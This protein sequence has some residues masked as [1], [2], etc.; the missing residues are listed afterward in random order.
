VA[1]LSGD[2]KSPTIN[3]GDGSQPTAGSVVFN[4]TSWIVLGSHLYSEEGGYTVTVTVNDPNHDSGQGPAAVGDAAINVT[5]NNCS[6]LTYQPFNGPVGTLVDSAASSDPTATF[7]VVIQWGDGMHSNGSVN[8]NTNPW[9]LIGGH[10]YTAVGTYNLTVTVTDD[11]GS[12]STCYPTMTVTSGDPPPP[13]TPPLPTASVPADG[14]AGICS[15]CGGVP[16]MIQTAAGVSGGGTNADPMVGNVRAFD[17]TLQ[18]AVNDVASSGFGTDWGQTVSWSNSPG[19]SATALNGNGTVDAQL[20]YLRQNGADNQ[21]IVI[22]DAS[23]ARYFNLNGSTYSSEFYLQE[24]LTHDTADKQFVLTDTTGDVIRFADFDSSY[25]AGQQGQFQSFTDPYGNVTA[26]TSRTT[27]G[28]PA[29]VQRSNTTGGTTTT[30]SF[31]YTY[32]SSGG[33]AGLISNVTLRRQVN[34]GAWSTVRQVVYTYYDGIAA[35]GNIGDLQLANVEDGSGNVLATEYY[36]YYT[37]ESG[38]YVHGLKYYFDT[39]AY[40]RLVTAVGSPTT[41]TDAQVANYADNYFQYNSAQQVTLERVQG[42]GSSFNQG[43]LG[44]YYFQ[45]LAAT[46]N[47]LGFNSWTY[48]TLETLPDGSSHTIYTNYAGEVMLDVFHDPVSG[49]NWETFTKYDSSGRAIWTAHTSAL[50]GYTESTADLLN[51]VNGNYQ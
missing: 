40:G 21:I 19:Y 44:V 2:L 35:Y 28:T 27:A 10:T 41:A 31:L 23:I 25:P 6:A 39:A 26:V 47:A 30:E 34:G 5:A 18:F 48:K 36:R 45:Y 42:E 8:K 14:G 1:I 24:T 17:G 33:N 7:S 32:V 22:S 11:G 51:S 9:T 46:G 38:G 15:T 49:N 16:D 3:W 37:G 43:G 4:G 29:E 50:T 20:P 12:T 13:G